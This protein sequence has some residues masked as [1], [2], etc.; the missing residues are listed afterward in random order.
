[1]KKPVPKTEPSKAKIEES[2]KKTKLKPVKSK[3]I[4]RSS[5]LS[6][7]VEDDLDEIDFEG[8]DDSL[9]LDDLETEED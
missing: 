4:K 2:K 9:Q 3:E 7:F 5:N 6:H 1:M 8:I